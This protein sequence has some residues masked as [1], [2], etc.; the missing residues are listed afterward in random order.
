[1]A[2]LMM[3][4][5]KKRNS[6]K[7]AT[8]EVTP[9]RRTPHKRQPEEVLARIIEAATEAFT[10]DGF[11]GARM[12]SIALEAG[13]SIQLLVHHVKS[14]DNLWQ[15]V[16]ESIFTQY[17]SFETKTSSLPPDTGAAEHLRH[18]IAD[19]VHYMAKH[20][21]LHRIMTHEGIKMS[22]RL[23]WLIETFARGPYEQF[24]ALTEEAQKEGHIR[25]DIHPGRLRYAAMA[26]V[27]FSVAAEYE[28]ILGKDPFSRG[29]V[30]STI[31]MIC[32]LVF[33][34]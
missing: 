31:D 15:M 27:P 14:K 23:V 30:A 11:K 16:M 13:I 21:E 2:F 5:A 34:K 6:T 24:V 18:M 26:S 33:A 29:E 28:Y 3:P 25:K 4:A 22:P 12:R 20:P 10:Q 19:F 9:K 8:A 17:S 32:K 1:L 7:S